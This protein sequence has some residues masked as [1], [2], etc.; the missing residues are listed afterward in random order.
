MDAVGVGKGVI[1]G[2]DG[3]GLALGVAEAVAL[4][5]ALGVGVG[6]PQGISVYCWLSLVGLPGPRS[7]ATA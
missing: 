2:S 6:V 7:P 1:D 4:G 3:V 5:V